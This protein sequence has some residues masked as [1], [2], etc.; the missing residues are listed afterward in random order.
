MLSCYK[1]KNSIFLCSNYVIQNLICLNINKL[2]QLKPTNT[3]FDLIILGGGDVMT[4]FFLN[5][6]NN[7]YYENKLES[8]PCHSYSMGITY[9]SLITL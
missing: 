5:I 1:F 8:V 7:W 9:L 3:D 2:Q 6:F 4:P